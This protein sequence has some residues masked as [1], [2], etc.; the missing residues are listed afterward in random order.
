MRVW[1]VCLYLMGLNLSN[2]QIT[3]ELGLH[4]GDVQEMTTQLRAGVV[5]KKS[6]SSYKVKSNAMKST[7]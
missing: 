6:P 2:L 4:Q 5:A 7:L 1:I 3:A